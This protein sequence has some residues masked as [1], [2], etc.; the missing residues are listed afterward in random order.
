MNKS[1]YKYDYCG[2]NDNYWGVGYQW[3]YLIWWN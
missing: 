2:E 1:C 3:K